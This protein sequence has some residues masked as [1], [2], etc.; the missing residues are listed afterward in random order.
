MQCDQLKEQLTTEPQHQSKEI[1]QH[2]EQCSNCTTWLTEFQKFER[3]LNEIIEVEVPG[4][5]EQRI[6]NQEVDKQ[7]NITQ[8]HAPQQ[9]HKWQPALALA[10]SLLLVIG[11]IITQNSQHSTQPFEQQVL[12]WLS[13]QHPAQYIDQ[14][15]SDDEI[16][17]MFHAVGAELVA[18]IGPILHCQVTQ[19]N[20]QKAGYF[21]IAGEQGPISVV[22]LA[23]GS[24]S[25][26]IQ[27]SVGANQKKNE[28]QIKAAISWI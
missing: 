6:L 8:L 17:G 21:I 18:D 4:G 15:A 27:S 9:L 14:Q 22:L 12:N 2:L 7:S 13:D 5:L 25:L 19:I 26:F 11:L 3:Q 10:A 28:Q 23:D 16:E 24:K 1:E 20:G